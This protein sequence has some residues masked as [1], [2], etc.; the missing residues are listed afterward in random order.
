ME[1][2]YFPFEVNHF[3][4]DMTFEEAFSIETERIENLANYVT[5]C[6]K[7]C[8]E[9]DAR[10]VT[11]TIVSRKQLRDKI[12]KLYDVW[13]EHL[14]EHCEPLQEVKDYEIEDE[15]DSVTF[16]PRRF[17]H[18]TGMQVFT[19]LTRLF[20]LKQ[21]PL[22]IVGEFEEEMVRLSSMKDDCWVKIVQ[23]FDIT[24]Q[25]VEKEDKDDEVES[26]YV[27]MKS[28][29]EKPI[30]RYT[31]SEVI[32][33]INFLVQQLNDVKEINIEEY[34]SVFETLWIR[35]AQM[36]ITLHSVESG[37]LDEPSMRS[38]TTIKN[39][40]TV[41]RNFYMFTCIYMV[42]ILRRFFYRKLF[43]GASMTGI[44]PSRSN[45][46]VSWIHKIINGFAEEAFIDLYVEHCSEVYVFPGDDK[47]YRYLYPKK[48]ASVGAYLAE[49]RPHLYR[50]Y[51]S[52]GQASKKSVLN[53]IDTSYIARSFV[54]KA[55]SAYIQIKTGITE[56]KFY[57]ACAIQ[58]MEL[59]F[60]YYTMTSNRCPLIVQAFSTYW[61]YDAGT[62]YPTD[63]IYA[64]IG[65]WFHLL[66]TKY[67]SKL[68]GF[69]MKRF[70]KEIEPPPTEGVEDI[71]GMG[72]QTFVNHSETQRM[73]LI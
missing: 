28:I 65:I 64:A 29:W 52:E 20:Y 26:R 9:E 54:L 56:V 33:V 12:L 2:K 4:R 40:Q 67:D 70:V 36:I 6:I 43:T 27:K 10:V 62:F 16:K 38:D 5:T 61:A 57:D 3:E 31:Q 35:V 59:S 37:V 47:W 14:I 58:S 51:F 17:K 48:I 63:D 50:R 8:G 25:Y 46:V 68:H 7:L 41:N 49:L 18:S 23:T 69:T 30:L 39:Y 66:K 34:Q 19:E 13:L 11:T 44:Q 71:R 60:S 22:L 45:A 73:F 1:E 53:A 24:D 55:V 72:N 15:L 32:L 21:R 42:P